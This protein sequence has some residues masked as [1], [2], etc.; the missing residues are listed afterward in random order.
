MVAKDF[1]MQARIIEA[2]I[3]SALFWIMKYDD[4]A[5]GITTSC[6]DSGYVGGGGNG[7][8]IGKMATNIT[9]EKAKLVRE[10]DDY[11]QIQKKIKDAIE[12]TDNPTQIKI[13]QMRYLDGCSWNE[14]YQET[15]LSESTVMKLHQKALKKIVLFLVLDFQRNIEIRLNLQ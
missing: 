12:F 2:K 1:L 4:I 5:T 10:L 13:L 3:N 14:I 8:K 7:D 15:R 6:S 9:D 11:I